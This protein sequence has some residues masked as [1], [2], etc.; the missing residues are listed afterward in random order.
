[1]VA[2]LRRRERQI[3][4]KLESQ[5]VWECWE[6]NGTVR[7]GVVST[8]KRLCLSKRA[9]QRNTSSYPI[10]NGYNR[11]LRQI[12][13]SMLVHNDALVPQTRLCTSVTIARVSGSRKGRDIDLDVLSTLEFF[14]CPAFRRTVRW[15]T[16]WERCLC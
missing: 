5:Q 4:F 7:R 11:L 6:T 16:D 1:M 8:D 15:V 9:A 14:D 13:Q 2:V 3:Q 10:L 12:S